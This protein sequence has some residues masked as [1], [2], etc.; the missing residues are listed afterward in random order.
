MAKAAEEAIDARA[1]ISN[2]NSQKAQAS[3]RL[4]LGEC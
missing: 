2:L 3:W 1:K 4:V